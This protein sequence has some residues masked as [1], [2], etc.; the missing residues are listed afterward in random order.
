M[1][2]SDKRWMLIYYFISLTECYVFKCQ[3]GS[4]RLG[5]NGDTEWFY[6]SNIF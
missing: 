6:L 3:K 5:E 4:N 1:A 2:L